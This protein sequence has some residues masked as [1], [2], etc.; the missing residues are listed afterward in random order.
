[1]NQECVG[2]RIWPNTLVFFGR[3]K[4]NPLIALLNPWIPLSH[5]WDHKCLML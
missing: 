1:M 4:S 5:G 3:I 2:I